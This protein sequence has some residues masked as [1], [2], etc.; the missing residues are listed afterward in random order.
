MSLR[1]A[2]KDTLRRI[3]SLNLLGEPEEKCKCG[4]PLGTQQI[5][6]ACGEMRCAVCVRICVKCETMTCYAC[7]GNAVPSLTG[8]HVCTKCQFSPRA[9]TT[10]REERCTACSTKT[11]RTCKRCDVVMCSDCLWACTQCGDGVCGDCI[12]ASLLKTNNLLVC[13][14]C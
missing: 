11:A 1:K 9:S 5:C 10:R 6:R 2:K 3:K 13:R 14:Q 7:C 4:R 12:N 8:A